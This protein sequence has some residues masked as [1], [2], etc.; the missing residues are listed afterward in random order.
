MTAKPPHNTQ[1]IDQYEHRRDQTKRAQ[2]VL[3]SAASHLVTASVPQGLRGEIIYD[4]SPIQVRDS[5]ERQAG[6]GDKGETVE[7]ELRL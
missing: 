4:Q 1:S 7:E 5:D 3:L 6:K 2:T